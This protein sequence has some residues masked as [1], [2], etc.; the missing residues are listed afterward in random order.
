MI[1]VKKS[2]HSTWLDWHGANFTDGVGITLF[3]S[4][5]LIQAE[6]IATEDARKELTEALVASK[7]GMFHLVAGKGVM[8]RDP[9]GTETSVTPAWRKTVTHYVTVGSPTALDRQ[10][11]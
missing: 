6:N 3:L 11:W 1:G 10:N 4:S 2:N 7:M 5:R 8:E 9:D